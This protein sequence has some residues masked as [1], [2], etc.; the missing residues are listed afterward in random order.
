[1]TASAAFGR[2]VPAGFL[3]TASQTSYEMQENPLWNMFQGSSVQNAIPE[4]AT[5]NQFL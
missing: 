3:G 2:V 1:M 5:F 4:I